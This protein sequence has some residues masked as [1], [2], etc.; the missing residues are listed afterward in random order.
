MRLDSTVNAARAALLVAALAAASACG[1]GS[2]GP[3]PPKARPA[4]TDERIRETLV[5]A[6]VRDVPEENA[7][8]EPITW[9][10]LPDEPTELTIVDRQMD[11]DK[12]TV[13]VDV[14]TRSSSRAKSPKALS[15]RIRLHYELQT[16]FVLRRWEVVGADNVSMKYRDLPKPDTGATPDGES[17][18]WDGPPAP[19]PPAT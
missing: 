18:D 12:A 14:T 6:R 7:A 8:A 9:H 10:F 4:L 16:E 19:P 1:S 15:G 3:R 17:D 2:E 5:D 11:G 13:T